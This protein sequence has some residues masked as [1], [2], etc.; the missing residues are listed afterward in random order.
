MTDVAGL[1]IVFF[2]LV[3]EDDFLG[4]EEVLDLIVT[5]DEY[6]NLVVVALFL[7]VV[8]VVVAAAAVDF[9]VVVLVCF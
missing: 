1:L 9:F 7:T 4:V 2:Q 5:M 3:V 8:V 6:N